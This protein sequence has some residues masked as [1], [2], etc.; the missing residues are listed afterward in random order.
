MKRVIAVF[1]SVMML[2]Q[3][4][5]NSA[6]AFDAPKLTESEWNTLYESYRYDNTLPT[7]NVG[8]DETQ[9]SL[10]WHADKSKAVAKVELSK[11]ADMSDAVLFEGEVTPAETG[12]QRV[13]R[14]TVTG[15]E[16]NTTYYYRWHIGDGWSET[17]E[18]ETKSFGKHKALVIGDIQITEDF[19]D[20]GTMQREDGLNWN[21]VL[22]ESLAKN[23]DIS[24]LVT[25][26]DN[27]GSG[28]TAGEWQTL[29][30]PEAMRS[31]PVAMAIGNHDKKGMMYEYYTN[32]PNEYYGKNFE[33]LDRDFWF[34]YGDVLYLFYN[35]T[36]GNAPDHRAMTKEAIELNSDAKWRIGVV[37]H[38]IY[39]AGDSIGDMETEILLKTIFAPIFESFD[40]DLVITGHTH[41]QGRSHFMRDTKVVQTAESGGTFTN[42]DGVVYLN[43][44]SCCG[45]PTNESYEAEHLAYSFLENDV[46]TYSTLEFDGDKMVLE[47]RRGDNSELLDTITI[48]HNE[49]YKEKSFGNVLKRLLYKVVEVIGWIYA[50]I[51]YLVKDIQDLNDNGGI[52]KKNKTDV[53]IENRADPYVTRGSDG[54]YYFTA[55]YPMCGGADPEGYD[56][57]ILR[58]ARTV[59]DLANA[60]EIVIW[61]E[62]DNP[63][64][65][66]YIWAPELHEIAG[67][68]YVYFAASDSADNVWD[69]R[70]H[71]IACEG[72]DPYTDKWVDKG[73]F[74]ACEGDNFSFR[75]FSLDMTYFEAGGKSYVSWAQNDVNSNVYIATVDPA[76][77]W[78]TTCP[79]VLLTKPEYDW[80]KV[81]IP[82]NEGPAVLKADGRVFLTFSASATGP[83]YCIGL[84]YAD[85][86]ADLTKPES[87]TKLDKPLLTSDDLYQEY[88]PGHNSFVKDECGSW[89]FVYHSRGK[90]CYKGRCGYSHEDSLY[91]PCRSARIR[92]VEWDEN[93]L[94]VLNK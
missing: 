6:A 83:E 62:K 44:N 8:A 79:A 39:G 34:R 20:D 21:N 60:E 23:S 55:S 35:S 80:E 10:C 5:V 1:M 26:G 90:D 63:T 76:E 9:V 49:E 13:C 51:D 78:K 2:M 32:M 89:V 7:L 68:W 27:T 36:S 64:A 29:L 77:P 15:L 56:R 88:G 43:S 28:R 42:P 25:P 11:N 47:T 58:R 33:R 14:V 48:I 37:H 50:K 19:A 45:R 91:D 75:W 94:P 85:E 73:R 17:E 70:C 57:I 59:A 18:Y 87:W 30:T 92:L 71:V 4:S 12:L 40:L 86:N 52:L 84:L 82:V 24:Y 53:F 38:G 3:L 66:R 31:L 81:K 22:A 46:T 93:G 65:H 41:S 61:D 69:I 16:E 74:Q 54:W 72:D 67:K